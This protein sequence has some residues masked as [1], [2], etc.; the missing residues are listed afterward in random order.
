VLEA[1]R[2]GRS[3]GIETRTAGHA[4]KLNGPV[5][6]TSSVTEGIEQA[7]RYCGQKSAELACVT[8]GREW[9]VFRGSRLGDGRDTMEGL[10]FVFPS[11]DAVQSHFALF[12][13]LLSYESVGKVLYRAHFQEAEGRPIRPHTFRTAL[14][15]QNSRRLLTNK[16]SNDLN[17]VMT[18]FF[19]RLSGDADPELLARCFVETR[20]SQSADE[21]LAHISEDLVGRIRNLDTGSGEQLTEVVERVKS[22]Q[23]TSSSLSSAPKGRGSRRLSI[24]SSALSCR[25]PC[26]KSA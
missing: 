22:T 6:N 21:R 20:E 12:Y 26:L 5:F 10:G 14:R 11:L 9:I 19:R 2:D 7:I 16:L 4:F 23:K 15:N 13:D 25:N 24:G 17:R 1:K 3:L 18:S 8:N